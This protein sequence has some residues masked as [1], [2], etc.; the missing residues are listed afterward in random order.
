MNI[1]TILSVLVPSYTFDDK[2]ANKQVNSQPTKDYK[3][4]L[5][6]LLFC[7]NDQVNQQY[8]K[9]DILKEIEVFEFVQ[10]INK[11][12]LINSFNNNIVNND[13]I[14]FLSDWYRINIYLYNDNT[15]VMKVYYPE[16]NLCTIKNSILV[17][18]QGESSEYK[19]F[20]TLLEPKV[21]R[22]NDNYIQQ[23]YPNVCLI[24]IGIQLNKILSLSSNL[25]SETMLTASYQ[26][27]ISTQN[28]F[29]TQENIID[30]IPSPLK[31]L[32]QNNTSYNNMTYEEMVSI[33]TQLVKDFENIK[34]KSIKVLC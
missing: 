34:K 7:I 2:I 15:R 31:L 5:D 19:M 29:I 18:Y 30:P 14:L 17:I 24:P 8:S 21:F 26:T 16:Q 3:N 4:T 22:F 23:L 27:N 11:I 10:G 32:N 25:E 28:D 6:D 9:Y 1:R 33:Y 20:K 13:V 12:K